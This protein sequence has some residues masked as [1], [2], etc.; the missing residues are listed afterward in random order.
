MAGGWAPTGMRSGERIFDEFRVK[1]Q[2]FMH[3]YCEKTT[4]VV[5]NRDRGGLIDPGEGV[6]M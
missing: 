1:I 2:G 6:K 3:F 4:L 5:R